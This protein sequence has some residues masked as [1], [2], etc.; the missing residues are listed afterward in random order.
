MPPLASLCPLAKLS[1]IRSSRSPLSLRPAASLSALRLGKPR[2]Q[3]E[4]W[5]VWERG[6]DP[7]KLPLFV[8]RRNREDADPTARLGRAGSTCGVGAAALPVLSN[9]VQNKSH[10]PSLT[11]R[12]IWPSLRSA[13]WYS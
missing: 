5:P 6:Q 8:Q 3:I 7:A 4:D 11:G 13:R 10:T 12:G 9:A 1:P 2:A